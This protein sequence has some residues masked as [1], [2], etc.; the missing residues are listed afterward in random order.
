VL[1]NFDCFHCTHNDC[2]TD[3]VTQE[4]IKEQNE[5]DKEIRYE[6]LYTAR[7]KSQFRYDNSDKGKARA[8]KYEQSEKGKARTRRY[9]QSEKGKACAKRKMQKLIQTG[10][11]AEKCRRYRERKKLIQNECNA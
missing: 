4:E 5:L 6:R 8:K 1:C 7:Q 9:E 2:F 10:K 11:N 3:I